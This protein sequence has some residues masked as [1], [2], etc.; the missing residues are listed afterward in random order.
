VDLVSHTFKW[1]GF[2]NNLAFRAKF[3]ESASQSKY[4]KY[5]EKCDY[6]C[7]YIITSWLLF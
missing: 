1:K 4:E 2:M 6:I 3:R 7:Y 5:E